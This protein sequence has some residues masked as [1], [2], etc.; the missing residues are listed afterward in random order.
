M[1]RLAKNDNKKKFAVKIYPKAQL[2][3]EDR[4]RNLEREI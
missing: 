1:V 2:T 4:K 3:D